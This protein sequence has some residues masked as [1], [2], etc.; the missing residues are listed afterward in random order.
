MIKNLHNI[1]LAAAGAL[2]LAGCADGST[3][4]LSTASVSPTATA[5][6]ADPACVALNQRINAL[7]Q[8]GVVERVEKAS[9]GKAKTVSVKRDALVKMTE[10]DKANAEFQAKCSLPLPAAAAVVPPAAPAPAA[11]TAAAKPATAAP[12]AKTASAAPATAG[13]AAPKPQ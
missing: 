8:E 10:L 1:A 6:K 12:A 9:E 4:L 3:G 2:A 13:A 7:R 5:A 11:N